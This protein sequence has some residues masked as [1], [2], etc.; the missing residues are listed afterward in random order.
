MNSFGRNFVHGEASGAAGMNNGQG[1]HDDNWGGGHM[2]Y[3]RGASQSGN[4]FGYGANQFGGVVV[5]MLAGVVFRI[6]SG[7][8]HMEGWH[9][10]ASMQICY[11]K[12]CKQWLRQ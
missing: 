11:T 12:Q 10:V 8:T 2:N 3:Q 5:T 7:L 1:F 4:R 9:G 6:D